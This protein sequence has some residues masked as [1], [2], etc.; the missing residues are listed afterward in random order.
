M[1]VLGATASIIAILHVTHRVTTYCL[2]IHSTIKRARPQITRVLN[3]VNS[4]R[5]ILEGLACLDDG[6]DSS[7]SLVHLK[8]I[9]SPGG[10]FDG[11]SSQL[12]ELE[13]ELGKFASSK[14]KSDHKVIMWALK[15]KDI[16]ACLERILRVNQSLQ[17]ALN[18]DQTHVLLFSLAY[19]ALLTDFNIRALLLQARTQALQLSSAVEQDSAS[20]LTSRT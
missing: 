5:T 17:S 14:T 4:L 20:M 16:N 12:K 6:D 7:S 1:E 15:E 8:A 18:L 19:A 2:D 10:L 9:L 11:C 3:E 13:A